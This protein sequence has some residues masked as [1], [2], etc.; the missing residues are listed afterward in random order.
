MRLPGIVLPR[1]SLR[2]LLLI[3]GAIGLAPLSALDIA[4][5]NHAKDI[6]LDRAERD[7]AELAHVV[8][9]RHAEV[10]QSSYGLLNVLS[11]VPAVRKASAGCSE[12]LSDLKAAHE[13]MT[14][15][16]VIDAN[17]QGICGTGD[18]T[19]FNI[20]GRQYFQEMQRTRSF[21]V[22][23]VMVGQRSKR[24]LVAAAMPLLDEAGNVERALAMG[25]DLAW[26]KQLAAQTA[27]IHGA[28]I[29]IVDR[30]G[31][32]IYASSFRTPVRDLSGFYRELPKIAAGTLLTEKPLGEATV[33]AV[34][35]L[36]DIG[37]TVAVGVSRAVVFAPIERAFWADLLLLIAVALGSFGVT[38]IFVE[39]GVSRGLRRI[40][41]AARAMAAGNLH[42]RAKVPPSVREVENLASSFNTMV[43]QLE[44]LAYHDRLTGL[45][46]RRLLE[47][48]LA[49]ATRTRVAGPFAVLAIDLDEFKPVNDAFGHR[50]GDEVLAEVAE[51]LTANATEADLVVRLGGDEFIV[52][53]HES[54]ADS[55]RIADR[56]RDAVARPYLVDNAE[57]NIGCC[58]GLAFV[59]PGSAIPGP[60]EMLDRADEALYEAKRGGRSRVV[61][62]A[63]DTD[64]VLWPASGAMFGSQAT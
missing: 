63:S 40:H 6:A 28:S 29:Y 34:E 47:R 8:A 13:S 30:G 4:R 19:T 46:N 36:A 16:L 15:L 39:L 49:N 50:A 5:L 12:I 11:S 60:V 1:L 64:D 9:A 51:R 31:A 38:V 55:A 21:T 35:R 24:E 27:A 57:V 56:L 61:V 33:F 52:V 2:C 10:I 42:E 54:R 32:P 37:V 26:L 48:Y 23:N 25:I 43:T 20:S 62:M 59:E 45:G 41:Q 58:I 14:N 7:M 17:G 53:L 22:S 18:P 44:G 3:A